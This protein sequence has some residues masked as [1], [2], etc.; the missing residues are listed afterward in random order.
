MVVANEVIRGSPFQLAAF[1]DADKI[2][3]ELATVRRIGPEIG[4]V[5]LLP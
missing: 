2:I 5:F 1:N 4:S 3:I